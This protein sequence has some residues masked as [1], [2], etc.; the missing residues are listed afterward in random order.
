MRTL[1]THPIVI[2]LMGVSGSGKST[3]GTALADILGWQ[4]YEGDDFHSE[5]NV[6]KMA[7]GIPLTDEDRE[8]WLANLHDLIAEQ[9]ALE[10]PAI[11]ACSALKQNYRD[12]LLEDNEGTMIVYLRGDYELIDQRMQKRQK[13]YMKADMLQSQFDA[14]E[15]PENAIVVSIEV[16]IDKI[17]DEIITTLN[18]N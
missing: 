7:Q 9:I 16:G 3:V 4:F 5:S 2:V 8:P 17:V 13:H 18:V 14:L 1:N 6:K 12:Q 11:I 15:E 10:K